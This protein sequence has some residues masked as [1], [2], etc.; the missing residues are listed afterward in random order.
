MIVHGVEGIL[1]AFAVE[2]P[3]RFKT[4]EVVSELTSLVVNYLVLVEPSRP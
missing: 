2:D 4:D 3:G 1:H